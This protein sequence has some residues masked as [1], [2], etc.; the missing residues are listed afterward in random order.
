MW[1]CSAQNNLEANISVCEVEITRRDG[2]RHVIS[3]RS[4]QSERSCIGALA[5][6][7]S[8]DRN[9]LIFGDYKTRKPMELAGSHMMRW[10]R[11]RSRHKRLHL[12]EMFSPVIFHG[13]DTWQY[14]PRVIRHGRQVACSCTKT[15]SGQKWHGTGGL[16]VAIS[17]KSCS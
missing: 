12:D 4:W 6:G 14:W 8:H 16:G 11:R 1:C 3:L 17:R 7:Y 2:T 10:A 15:R 9:A 5:A 13:A